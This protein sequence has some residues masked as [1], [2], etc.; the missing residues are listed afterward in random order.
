MDISKNI[1]NEEL[2]DAKSQ[3]GWDKVFANH[4]L[5]KQSAKEI[6]EKYITNNY[7]DMVWISD[8]YWYNK[9]QVLDQN[10]R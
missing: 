1:F 4:G 10:K 8:G 3:Q 5:K 2:V 9:K 6:E 7:E